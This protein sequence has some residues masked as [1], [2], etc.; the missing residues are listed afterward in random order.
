MRGFTCLAKSDLYTS[1]VL[2][3]DCYVF[4][5]VGWPSAFPQ[6][7]QKASWLANAAAVIRKARQPR[8][9]PLGKAWNCIRRE[10]FEFANVDPRFD[11]GA[12]G[13]DIGTVQISNTEQFDVLTFHVV[14]V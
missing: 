2:L 10:V 3:L 1:E 13:P 12:V 14:P 6:S 5:D 9:Q 7:Q 4:H 8:R 11:Y